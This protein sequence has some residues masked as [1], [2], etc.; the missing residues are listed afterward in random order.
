MN[1]MLNKINAD[2]HSRTIARP[3]QATLD[4]FA[5]A[6][7]ANLLADLVASYKSL[8]AKGDLSSDDFTAIESRLGTFEGSFEVT[9]LSGF[10]E[11]YLIDDDTETYDI[12]VGLSSG[13]DLTIKLAVAVERSTNGEGSFVKQWEMFANDESV[14]SLIQETDSEEL[15][16]NF[17]I[18]DFLS[19]YEYDVNQKQIS[20]D[21]INKI[22]AI[23]G[24]AA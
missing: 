18:S 5:N 2:I 3:S 23:L 1:T 20:D 13:M 24:I 4:G 16:E 10:G 9:Q 21:D 7:N 12:E 14:K 19:E 15:I 11:P 22:A 8:L 6:F 17:V